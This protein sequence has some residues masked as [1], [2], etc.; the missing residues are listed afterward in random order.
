MCS[1]CI[2]TFTAKNR[3]EGFGTSTWL[4]AWS[5]RQGLCNR[6]STNASFTKAVLSMFC[7]LTTPQR[8]STAFSGVELAATRSNFRS[9]LNRNENQ[10]DGAAALDPPPSYDDAK[11]YETLDLGG[12]SSTAAVVSMALAAE[13]DFYVEEDYHRFVGSLRKAG[14]KGRIVIGV[15]EKAAMANNQMLLYYFRFR[16]VDPLIVDSEVDGIECVRTTDDVLPLVDRERPCFDF[17]P[18]GLVNSKA[19]QMQLLKDWIE[20]HCD[21]CSGPILYVDLKSTFFQA[22]PFGPGAPPVRGLQLHEVDKRSKIGNKSQTYKAIKDCKG[23]G[24]ASKVM[25]KVTI[26]GEAVIGTRRAMLAY[27]DAMSREIDSWEQLRNCDASN[28][29]AITNYMFYAR[30]LPFANA[31]ENGGTAGIVKSVGWVAKDI[32]KRHAKAMTEKHKVS[33]E[34]GTSNKIAPIAV[35]VCLLPFRNNESDTCLDQSALVFSAKAMP[36]I[37]SNSATESH[38]SLKAK[39]W[40]GPEHNLVDDEGYFVQVDGAT[41]S[42]VV[43]QFDGFSLNLNKDLNYW[44]QVNSLWWD[45]PPISFFRSMRKAFF[46]AG[47]SPPSPE[48][49]AHNTAISPTSRRAATDTGVDLAAPGLYDAVDLNGDSSSATVISMATGYGLETYERFVGSLRKS[50]FKGH[51]ILGVSHVSPEVEKYFKWRNVTARVVEMIPAEECAM[52]S[53]HLL[54]IV[55]AQPCSKAY[56]QLKVTWARHSLFRDWLQECEA[57]TGPVLFVDSRDTFFQDD[58]FGPGSPPV[59]GLQV[60]Q[61][62]EDSSTKISFVGD[63]IRQCKGVEYDAPMLCAGVRDFFSSVIS[64]TSMI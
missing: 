5:T 21:T 51:I 52:N 53:D 28:S 31:V 33:E 22:D 26:T 41:R 30:R 38:K 35:A 47:V 8:K 37:E 16:G 12:D 48:A 17:Y 15:T 50:G 27:L 6:R 20:K 62:G 55:R 13:P 4:I 43:Y 49:S 7:A 10:R 60:Y 19:A 25:D 3:P 39:R 29:H 11:L 57:C 64:F 2:G 36:L 9:L 34:V 44:L 24:Q 58:P 40:I 45:V 42:R 54:P 63:A 14:Y 56:P 32:I 1:E 59:R 23:E 61:V 18:D 46:D